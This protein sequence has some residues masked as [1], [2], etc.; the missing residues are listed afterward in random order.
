MNC[1]Y[2]REANFIVDYLV[3]KGAIER[4]HYGLLLKVYTKL[5]ILPYLRSCFRGRVRKREREGGRE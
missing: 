1:S 5:Y 3:K 4:N 2:L